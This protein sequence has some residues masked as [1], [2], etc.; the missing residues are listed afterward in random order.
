MRTIYDPL[1][2]DL[3]LYSYEAGFIQK[4]IKDKK[5]IEANAF[6]LIFRYINDLLS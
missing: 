4:L 1:I 2:V 6:N 5:N 3:F